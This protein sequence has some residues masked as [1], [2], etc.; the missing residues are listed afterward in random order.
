MEL[1]AAHHDIPRRTATARK[2]SPYSMDANCCISLR[3]RVLEDTWAGSTE[4]GIMWKVEQASRKNAPDSP[5]VP[6]KTGP[7]SNGGAV[8]GGESTAGAVAAATV[9]A[10]VEPQ[11][12]RKPESAVWTCVRESASWHEVAWLPTKRPAY[13]QC[14][15]APPIESIT[16]GAV[17]V[18]HLKR[19]ALI[20]K[21]VPAVYN[22]FLV[23]P[24]TSDE[25]RKM[26]DAS[27]PTST[28]SPPETLT[29]AMC[30]CWLAAS[31]NPPG[32]PLFPQKT[33][34]F[35]FFFW[36]KKKIFWPA[37][38]SRPF[39]DECQGAYESGRCGRPLSA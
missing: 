28:R 36:G 5:T 25:C 7:T 16:P 26:I 20:R 35:V 30:P 3:G 11:L 32:P 8:R 39:E 29:R 13:H 4:R 15:K 9:L 24:G 33:P 27:R 21:Y 10:G 6:L 2:R 34:N 1:R 22:G 17:E 38:P 19:Q 31:L 37:S 12:V 18:A 23:E 14:S